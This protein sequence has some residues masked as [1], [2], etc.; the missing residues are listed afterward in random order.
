MPNKD[1]IANTFIVSLVLCVVCSLVV[2]GAAVSLRGIQEQ[3]KLIDRYRNIVAASGISE[4]PVK[5][6]SG[7]EVEELFKSRFTKELLDLSTGEYVED[8]DE[9]FEPKEAAKNE[10][11]NVD[12]TGYD[13]GLA[14]REPKTWVYLVKGDSGNVEQVV[15]PVYGMGLWS[16]LYGYVAVD[17]DFRTVKGLT[18]YEHAETPGL[19]GEVDN[20]LWK[21]KWVGKQIWAEGEPRVDDNLR[22]GVAKG[23]PPAGMEDYMVDGLS[24]ATITSRGVDSMLKYWFSDEGFGPYVRK[25][26]SEG[27]RPSPSG[28]KADAA[29]D[30]D[31]DTGAAETGSPETPADDSEASEPDS[32]SETTDSK[33]TEQKGESDG[34][35]EG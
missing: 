21:E 15:L 32:D 22:V 27:D 1:S 13:I 23:G 11:I 35:S 12:I 30:S 26:A 34:G 29:P 14:K 19:G 8:P 10:E 28:E 3:N 25:L 20:P 24:G 18:Y 31:E 9:N 7:A 33:T 2:S 17:S 5:E 4:T 6:L 16:T